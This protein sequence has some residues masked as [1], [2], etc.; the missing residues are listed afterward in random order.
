MAGRRRGEIPASLARGRERFEAWRRDRTP[1]ARIP[2]RLWALAV[3]LADAHGLS[4]T[5]SALKLD[6]YSLKKRLEASNSDSISMPPTFVEVSPPSSAASGECVIEFEDGSG[7]SLRVHL[8][9]C[10]T[11]DLAALVRCF[12]GGE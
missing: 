8:R 1:G 7:A 3:K 5:A 11:P 6:Y 12:R 4:R 9:G 2:D 10:E